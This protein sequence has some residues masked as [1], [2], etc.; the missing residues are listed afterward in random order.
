[1]EKNHLHDALS[2]YL[3]QHATN[4]VHWY[5]WG[6]EALAKAKAE[7]KPILLSIGYSACHWCHVM[8]HESFEDSETA[9]L[10]NKLFVN[11]KVDKE[12][13]PDLDKVYQTAHYL[14]T[15]RGGGWPLTIFLTPDDLAPF[16]S[17][18]YFP[19]DSHYQLPVFKEVLK[20]IAETYHN[21]TADIRQQNVELIKALQHS[22]KVITNT[23]L[24]NQ[25]W[26]LAVEL[27]QQHYDNAHGGFGNAPKFP[28]PSIIEFLLSNHSPMALNTLEQMGKGGI[29]DQLG[30][31][32]FR[33]S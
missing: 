1:M 31:G 4:P 21:R 11:I 28:Q 10:M 25:P 30:G 32:F 20:A 27:L 23:L 6:K 16:F 8:A 12:E 9:N 24:N 14:L 29:F 33:Y 5:P 13:R 19:K 17:G 15:Q 26:Q 22:D 3:Q 7:N 18:T 2:P